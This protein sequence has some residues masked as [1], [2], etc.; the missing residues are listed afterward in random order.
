LKKY[1]VYVYKIWWWKDGRVTMC[2]KTCKTYQILERSHFLFGDFLRCLRRI[3]KLQPVV[4]VCTWD[5]K[6]CVMPMTCVA[7]PYICGPADGYP[8]MWR[9]VVPPATTWQG[10]FPSLKGQNPDHAEK[11]RWDT[12]RL[13]EHRSSATWWL[14]LDRSGNWLWT[15]SSSGW[16]WALAR[17]ICTVQN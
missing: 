11:L 13:I 6:R 14:T 9:Y 3:C 5:V 8:V 4:D 7:G 10:R 2:H 12:R 1:C 17:G 15:A 16:P